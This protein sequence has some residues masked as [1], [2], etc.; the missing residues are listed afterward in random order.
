[1]SRPFQPGDIVFSRFSHSRVRVIS[2]NPAFD[3]RF[4][5][6]TFIGY[7]GEIERLPQH[8]YRYESW[9]SDSF[10]LE[11]REPISGA[12]PTVEF[13]PSFREF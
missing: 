2:V 9:V 12:A 8:Q 6:G 1:M 4:F 3:G 10:E 5:A 7:R 13:G 11:A